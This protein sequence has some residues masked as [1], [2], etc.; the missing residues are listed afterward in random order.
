MPIY[1]VEITSG[2]N[3]PNHAQFFTN[4]RTNTEIFGETIFGVE[5][6]NTGHFR[7]LFVKTHLRKETVHRMASYS[8]DGRGFYQ[9]I[10]VVTMNA[11]NVR[12]E[13]YKH[14]RQFLQQYF[15]AFLD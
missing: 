10:K 11:R 2:K 9:D 5:P 7:V 15:K 14:Y 8:P 12:G 1:F 4:L 6:D 13:N 3:N